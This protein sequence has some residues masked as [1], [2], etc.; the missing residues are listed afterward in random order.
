M[1]D[2]R[3]GGRAA[4]ARPRGNA[5]LRLRVEFAGDAEAWAYQ[6]ALNGRLV[7]AVYVDGVRYVPA[8]GVD[9]DAE[10]EVD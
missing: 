7:D 1:S 5:V 4:Y 8:P 9:W 3:R 10:S 2:C 6:L